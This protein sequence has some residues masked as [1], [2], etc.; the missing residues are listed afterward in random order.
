MRAHI[1]I[2]FKFLKT[3]NL[4]KNKKKKI[5]DRK[6]RLKTQNNDIIIKNNII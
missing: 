5:T 1:Q 6:K 3:D 4:K 2:Y